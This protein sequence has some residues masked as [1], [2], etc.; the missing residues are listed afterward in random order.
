[1]QGLYRPVASPDLR[2]ELFTH[3]CQLL[4]LLLVR[5]HPLLRLFSSGRDRVLEL[6]FESRELRLHLTKKGESAMSKQGILW[7]SLVKGHPEIDVTLLKRVE[8][9]MEEMMA[10]LQKSTGMHAMDGM[11]YAKHVREGMD[12]APGMGGP[13]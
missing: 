6:V 8:K 10:D 1:M 12:G 13:Q 9:S 5:L 7:P 11:N 4:H 3:L 2:R